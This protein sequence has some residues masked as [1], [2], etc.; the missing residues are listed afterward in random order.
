[1]PSI[2]IIGAGFGGLSVA[3]ELLRRG[4]DGVRLWERGDGVG[5]VWRENTYPGAACDVPSHLYSLS[6]EPYPGWTSRYAQQPQILDYLERTA[7]R[8]GVAGRV[9]TGRTVVAASFDESRAEWTTTFADGSQQRT[10]ILVSAVG[11]LSEPALPRI[12]GVNSFGGTSFHSAR[13]DHDADLS[14]RVAVIGT[15]A[16]AIQFVPHLARTA[17]RLTVFQRTPSYIL[18][19]PDQ[20]YGHRYRA[21]TGRAPGVI[22]RERRVYDWL[23]EQF[24]RG[25]EADSAA[26]RA[27][28]ALALGHLRAR[29]HDPELRAKLTP[30]Y[31]IGCRRILFANSYYP[32]L[33]REN[34]EVVTEPIDEVTETGVR[35]GGRDHEVDTIVYGTGFDAQSFLSTIDVTGPRG[36][37]AEQWSDGARAY[38]GIHVPGFP[39]LMLSYGPNTNLGG[40]SIVYMLEAQAHAIGDAVDRLRATGS[41]TVEVTAAAERTWDDDVQA[42]LAGTVWSRCDSW[43]R[44]PSGRITSN[45]PGPT[46]VYGRRT[47][48]LDPE[49]FT[50]T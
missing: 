20:R 6:Y 39:N 31:A 48:H 36:R 33:T 5:G 42:R 34:V 7:G 3:I 19:R 32:A 45:W 30:D 23:A 12:P 38:L 29:V 18:P 43:Y 11:Q 37:L 40:N 13:W 21:L 26:G 8:Y 46:H 44:H 4:H 28:R 9:Q 49:A 27:I 47:A 1:M 35:A 24:T 25:L 17:R 50:W 14:G 41:R 16:S 10:D 15:G 22:D 2:G